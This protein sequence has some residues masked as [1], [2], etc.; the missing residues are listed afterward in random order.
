MVRVVFENVTSALGINEEL[1]E[2]DT[3]FDPEALLVMKSTRQENRSEVNCPPKG[4]SI[5]P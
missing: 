4:E 2:D 1:P 3:P 5:F